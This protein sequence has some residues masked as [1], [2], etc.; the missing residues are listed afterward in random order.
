M[1]RAD[2]T[3][4]DDG[5]DAAAEFVRIATGLR[6]AREH[7]ARYAAQDAARWRPAWLTSAP[8]PAWCHPAL[9]QRHPEE[10]GV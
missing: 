8:W 3:P 9:P 10:G 4:G 7:R 2:Q 1:T 5:S 6:R